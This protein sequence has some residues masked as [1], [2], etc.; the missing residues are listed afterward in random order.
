MPDSLH[1][2]GWEDPNRD[3]KWA[4]PFR[5]FSSREMWATIAFYHWVK[6]TILHEAILQLRRMPGPKVYSA[7]PC[8]PVFFLLE[9]NSRLCQRPSFIRATFP[10][11]IWQALVFQ[12]RWEAEKRRERERHVVSACFI[13][14]RTKRRPRQS[15]RGQFWSVPLFCHWRII[16]TTTNAG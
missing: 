16:G 6:Y 13:R 15:V 1:G 8:V 9:N 7:P 2:R 4:R 5:T 3:P 12:N 11:W 14:R 10:D